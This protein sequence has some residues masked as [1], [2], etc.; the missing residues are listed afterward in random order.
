MGRIERGFLAIGLAAT[1]AACA[2]TPS[3]PYW[4]DQHWNE[5]LFNALQAQIYYPIG[6]HDPRTEPVT[7]TVGFTYHRGH[8]ED[9]TLVKST[10]SPVLD[11]TM[12]HQVSIAKVPLATGPEADT[13]RHYE[14]GLRMPTPLPVFYSQ[15]Q[16]QAQKTASY[17]HESMLMSESGVV[18]VSFD[19]EA[20]HISNAQVFKSSGYEALDKAALIDVNN[21][22]IPPPVE[23]EHDRMHLQMQI[24]YNVNPRNQDKCPV[25]KTVIQVVNAQ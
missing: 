9:V 13:P 4:E 14:L 3:G 22:Q 21:L 12:V 18:E 10:D 1:L 5:A 15:V 11:A 2:S 20:G 7:G 16:Q 24:C 23:H 17:P 25:H 8:L 19:Y 6:T